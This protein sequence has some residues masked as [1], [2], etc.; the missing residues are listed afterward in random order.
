[1]EPLGVIEHIGPGFGQRQVAPP[2]D[3]LAFEVAEEAF[4]RRVVPQG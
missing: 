1:M 3:P 2:V 4:R